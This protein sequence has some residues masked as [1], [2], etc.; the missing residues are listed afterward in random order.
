MYQVTAH[1]LNEAGEKGGEV[2]RHINGP[3]VGASVKMQPVEVGAVVSDLCDPR[4]C[5]NFEKAGIYRVHIVRLLSTDDAMAYFLGK[6]QERFINTK[7]FTIE[8]VP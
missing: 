8:V 5:L 3:G 6:Q 1:W 7:P 4:F 2:A